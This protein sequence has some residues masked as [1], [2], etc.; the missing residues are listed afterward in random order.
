MSCALYWDTYEGINWQFRALSAVVLYRYNGIFLAFNHKYNG[1][2]LAFNHK[3]SS[4]SSGGKSKGG[5]SKDLA[6]QLQCTSIFRCA[7]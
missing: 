1:I 3:K 7:L 2:F 4:C 6:P 5:K